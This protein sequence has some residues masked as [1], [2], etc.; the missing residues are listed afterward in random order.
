MGRMT[1]G[2]VTSS[3]SHVLLW[4]AGVFVAHAV[5]VAVLIRV[6]DTQS[7][8][9]FWAIHRILRLL[10]FWVYSWVLPFLNKPWM[11]NPL[12]TLE[13]AVGVKTMRG[14]A[15]LYEWLMVS[16]FGGLIYA[17]LVTALV[18]ARQRRQGPLQEA[19]A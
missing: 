10:E 4:F 18:V 3:G 16:I 5:A 19:A 7:G 8:N 14:S 13:T 9:V 11:A 1:V 2:R 12:Y 15:E 6:R 17:A